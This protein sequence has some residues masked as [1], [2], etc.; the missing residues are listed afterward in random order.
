[1]FAYLD[2]TVGTQNYVV[3]LSA[4][5]GV[6]PI[7]E[8]MVRDGFDAGRIGTVEVVDRIEKALAPIWGVGK[9]VARMTYPDLYFLPGVYAKLL[10][11]PA[12]MRAVKEAINGVPGVL[13]IYGSEELLDARGSDD[14]MKRAAALSFYPGRSGDM[15]IVP[16]PYWFFVT[17][18]MSLSAGSATTHGSLYGYDQHVPVILMGPGIHGG[19]YLGASSPAD[20]APTLAFL[21]GITLARADGRVLSEA[22]D[23]SRNVKPN[24]AKQSE[25]VKKP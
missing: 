16:K 13:R 24:S 25:A 20:I 9:Y 10:A 8:R 6:A 1:L 18:P 2:R 5:H 11:D 21:C 7:P 23:V 14:P 19:E 15:V 17:N 4:D 12:A 22:L 3:A